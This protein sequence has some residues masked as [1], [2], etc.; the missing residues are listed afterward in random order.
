MEHGTAG[1][2]PGAD[3]EAVARRGGGRARAPRARHHG[4]G[5]RVGRGGAG[6]AAGAPARRHPAA[7]GAQPA[8]RGRGA[9][10]PSHS[11]G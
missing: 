7:G 2:V 9:L 11:Q 8:A 6:R 4:L 1:G 10:G 5:A 3:A